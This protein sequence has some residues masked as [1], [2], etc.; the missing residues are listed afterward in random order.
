MA[1][2]STYFCPA[3]IAA[4]P[5]SSSLRRKFKVPAKPV[6]SSTPFSPSFGATSTRAS[7]SRPKTNTDDVSGNISYL[8][9]FAPVPRWSLLFGS[10]ENESK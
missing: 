1:S 7:Y 4:T 8:S 2:S 3:L 9:S 5:P 6:G 10:L